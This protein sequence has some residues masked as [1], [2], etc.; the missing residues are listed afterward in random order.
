MR[1]SDFAAFQRPADR[2]GSQQERRGR[3]L[4]SRRRH[5]ELALL[6]IVRRAERDARVCSRPREEVR[7]DGYSRCPVDE[8]A[9]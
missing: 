1:V 8:V 9:G 4:V 2:P 3:C 6:L 7:G 5:T